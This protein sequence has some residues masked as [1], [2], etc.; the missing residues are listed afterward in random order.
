MGGG[1]FTL[2]A[3]PSQWVKPVVDAVML[4]AH[5]QT[6]E[7]EP[8]AR[9]GI[10]VPATSLLFATGLAPGLWDYIIPSANASEPSIP[11]GFLCIARTETGW[12]ASYDAGGD[13]QVGSGDFGDCVLLVCVGSMRIKATQ[14]KEDG[15][16]DFEL[17]GNLADCTS[18]PPIVSDT[19]NEP[20]SLGTCRD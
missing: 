19:T 17:Y 9:N 6:T 11:A 1:T 13:V 8:V 12:E 18:T 10:S 4:P 5:A 15:S 20:C 16:F 3:L 14:E 7:T 2:S